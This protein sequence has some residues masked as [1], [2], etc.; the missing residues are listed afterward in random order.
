MKLL[1]AGN[2]AKMKTSLDSPIS[3]RLPVG[4]DLVDMNALLGKRISL[5]FSSE[6]NCIP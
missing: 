1:A 6:I 3:Y 5:E 4:K 2:I